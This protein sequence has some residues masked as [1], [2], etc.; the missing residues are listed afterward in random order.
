MMCTAAVSI[1]PSYQGKLAGL[2]GNGNTAD[3]KFDFLLGW[4][5]AAN[6]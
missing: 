1:P 3:D 5:K 6:D 2:M 4:N